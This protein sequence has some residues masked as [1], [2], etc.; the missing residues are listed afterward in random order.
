[1]A[2]SLQVVEKP[3]TFQQVTSDNNLVLYINCDIIRQSKH[4]R[5]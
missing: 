3:T 2:V 5:D 1:M 4:Y